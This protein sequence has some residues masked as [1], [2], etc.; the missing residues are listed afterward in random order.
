MCPLLCGNCEESPG[1]DSLSFE[2]ILHIPPPRPPAPWLASFSPCPCPSW[3]AEEGYVPASLI[4]ALTSC[5]PFPG[6]CRLPP[7][8]LVALTVCLTRLQLG[9]SF[10]VWM[11]I[12]YILSLEIGYK[13]HQ[14]RHICISFF[15]SFLFFFP[16]KKKKSSDGIPPSKCTQNNLLIGS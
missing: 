12:F 3:P 11:T 5:L 16:L 1:D 15:F 14:C 10:L 7:L 9:V 6:Q 8:S 4:S 13:F 2:C